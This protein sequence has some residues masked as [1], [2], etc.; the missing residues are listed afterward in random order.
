[1]Q[2]VVPAQRAVMRQATQ[3]AVQLDVHHAHHD[4]VAQLERHVAR[5][6]G[7][8]E[9]MERVGRRYVLSL[10][11]SIACSLACSLACLGVNRHNACTDT[12][13]CFFGFSELWVF[14]FQRKT[15][16]WSGVSVSKAGLV[17]I[18]FS[19]TTVS[20]CIQMSLL[21]IKTNARMQIPSGQAVKL[22]P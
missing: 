13:F 3:G 17:G 4:R 7:V 9:T 2:G 22:S 16:A 19:S 15:S 6:G 8:A 20:K 11:A 21:F 1:M 18:P 12:F 5:V 10:L 14:S